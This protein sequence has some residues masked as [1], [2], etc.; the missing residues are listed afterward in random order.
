MNN[1]WNKMAA[2]AIVIIITMCILHPSLWIGAIGTVL[3]IVLVAL[4][5]KVVCKLVFGKSISELI[6]GD[7]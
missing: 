3:H 4:V 2:M 5:A 7:K 6:F 1:L